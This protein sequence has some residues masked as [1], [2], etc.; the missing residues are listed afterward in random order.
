M[1][2][3]KTTD[4][5]GTMPPLKTTEDIAKE[6]GRYPSNGETISSLKTTDRGGTMPPLKTT[7]RGEMISSLGCPTV[8]LV[9]ET[10][11]STILPRTCRQ[12]SAVFLTGAIV[13]ALRHYLPPANPLHIR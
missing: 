10:V 12:I 3:P 4:K 2:P 11:S 6:V 8:V 9:D 13:R 1:P 5:G 7:D